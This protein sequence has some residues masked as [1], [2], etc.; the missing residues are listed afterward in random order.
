MNNIITTETLAK[1]HY[2]ASQKKGKP[3]IP[4]TKEKMNKLGFYVKH[5]P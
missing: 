3:L 4:S 1:K 5:Q 2:S